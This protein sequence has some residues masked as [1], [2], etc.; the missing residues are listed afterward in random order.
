M[1]K[2]GWYPLIARPSSN[3]IFQRYLQLVQPNHFI[4]WL[5][6]YVI[7][8]TSLHMLFLFTSLAH[9]SQHLPTQLKTTHY[10]FLF[11]E[12]FRSIGVRGLSKMSLVFFKNL[13]GGWCNFFQVDI[14]VS[15]F[16]GKN[17]TSFCRRSRKGRLT[18]SLASSQS[19]VEIMVRFASH[20]FSVPQ[21]G[22][23]ILKIPSWR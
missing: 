21:W 22:Q 4:K 1:M 20:C 5:E 16:S 17:K 15:C 8:K 9:C 19:R 23:N 12:H 11:R 2:V 13:F 10:L 3:C 18:S 14:G 7:D 6:M